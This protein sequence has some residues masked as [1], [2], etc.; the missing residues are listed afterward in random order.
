MYDSEIRQLEKSLTDI[1]IQSFNQAAQAFSQLLMQKMVLSRYRIDMISGE[2]F[3]EQ[4]GDKMEDGYFASIIR[5]PV[6]LETVILFFL[7]EEEGRRLYDRLNGPTQDQS[8]ISLDDLVS[9]IGE[10]NNILGNNFVNCL[11]NT[12]NL[13]IHGSVPRN[14]LDLLGA[15]LQSIILQNDFADKSIFCADANISDKK[16]TAFNVRLVIL[17]DKEKL[18]QVISQPEAQ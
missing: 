8:A 14:T 12:L 3:I 15:I 18:M 2:Q 7:A 6:E 1:F 5:L 11:A 10:L 16:S 17:S 9:S 13:S 4:L